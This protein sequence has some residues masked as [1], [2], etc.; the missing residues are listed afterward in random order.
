MAAHTNKNSDNSHTHSVL[1][2]TALGLPG[3]GGVACVT[4]GVEYSVGP[5]LTL[6]A[7]MPTESTTSCR[8]RRGNMSPGLEYKGRPPCSTGIKIIL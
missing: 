2:R 3:G 5:H 8:V 1:T 4:G 6:L 7:A